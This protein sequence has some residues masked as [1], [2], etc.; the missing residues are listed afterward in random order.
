MKV[1]LYPHY[2]KAIVAA[3]LTCLFSHIVS[4]ISWLWPHMLSYLNFKNVN[5]LVSECLVW[6][7]PFLK[8]DNGTLC[9]AC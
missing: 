7:L 9:D 2:M 3:P 6:V 8:F 1:E 5:R 4:D